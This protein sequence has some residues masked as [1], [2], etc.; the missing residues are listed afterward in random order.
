MK[1][2]GITPAQI[3]RKSGSFLSGLSKKG[4]AAKAYIEPERPDIAADPVIKYMNKE[5]LEKAIEKSKKS[6]EKS[7]FRT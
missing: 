3:I 5:A 2:W 4:K 7:C 6:M 1:R